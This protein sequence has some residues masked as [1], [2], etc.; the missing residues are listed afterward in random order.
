MAG[1]HSPQRKAIAQREEAED[2][3][4]KIEKFKIANSHPTVFGA[5]LNPKQP[6]KRGVDTHPQTNN[7]SSL[8]AS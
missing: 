4:S 3:A 5:S 7:R 8:I 2:T 1:V 6:G